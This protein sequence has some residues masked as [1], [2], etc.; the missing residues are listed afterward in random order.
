MLESLKTRP[1]TTLPDDI[2]FEGRFL[3]L[4]EDPALVRSQLEGKDLAWTPEIALRNDI[5][6]DEITPAYICYYYDQTL[7]DFPYLGLKCGEEFPVTRGSVR[8]GDFVASVSGKRRGK[9]SSREQSPYAELMAG[10]RLVVAEN[11]E[12]IYRR[13]L[14]EPRRLHQHRFLAAG[15]GAPRRGHPAVGVHRRR[16]RDHPR[17]HRARRALPVQRGAHAGQ[18]RRCRR[19]PRRGGR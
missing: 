17:H 6:T 15:P 2:R 7:G 4:T 14:P 9:G 1:I 16:G 18:G 8:A 5:S 3:Y 12:R 19:S 13:K 10:I 11:I